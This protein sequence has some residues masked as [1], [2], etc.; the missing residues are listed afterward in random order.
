MPYAYKLHISHGNVMYSQV[1]A[2]CLLHHKSL[3]LSLFAYFS[4]FLQEKKQTECTFKD[5]KIPVDTVVSH[6]TILALTSGQGNKSLALQT[7]DFHV[8]QKSLELEESDE[9][10]KNTCQF[11]TI[12]DQFPLFPW[13]FSKYSRGFPNFLWFFPCFPMASWCPLFGS[14]EFWAPS[15]SCSRHSRRSCCASCRKSCSSYENR[16]KHEDKL[17]FFLDI[18]GNSINSSSI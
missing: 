8:F 5:N 2:A 15:A 9:T 14:L 7:S 12:L 1:E 10:L 17:R 4:K 13:L 11:W 16:T 3:L 6:Q 18:L